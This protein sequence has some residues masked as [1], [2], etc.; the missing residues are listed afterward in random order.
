MLVIGLIIDQ[1]HNFGLLPTYTPTLPPTATLRPTATPPPTLTP[2]ITPT[3]PPTETPTVT[4]TLSPDQALITR[5]EETLGTLNRD[6]P[7]RVTVSLDGDVINVK[8]AI[9]DNLTEDL[10]KRGA[11]VDIK[12]TLK[13]VDDAGASFSL[14]NIEG[15]F[16]LADKLGNASEETVVWATY[17]AATV[18]QVNWPNFLTDNVYD[19]AMTYKLHPVF[20]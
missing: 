4:P 8:I 18:S 20:Q 10:I 17:D 2:T 16:S 14:I 9:G 6:G 1:A 12:D 19:I 7:S 13:A 15:T 3:S 5:I 11:K